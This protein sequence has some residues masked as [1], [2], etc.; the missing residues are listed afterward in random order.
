MVPH[1]INNWTLLLGT[2]KCFAPQE[3]GYAGISKF[4]KYSIC[5]VI[6]LPHKLL[7]PALG[8]AGA[9]ALPR[10]ELELVVFGWRSFTL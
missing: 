7:D 4:Q 10:E 9:R 2:P 8:V 1:F 6:G 5:R 3:A